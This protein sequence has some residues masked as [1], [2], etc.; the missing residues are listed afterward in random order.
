[1]ADRTLL[2]TGFQPF[3]SAPLNPSE[4]LIEALRAEEWAP[5]GARLELAVL[6]T[7]HD[8]WDRRL[9]LLI[10]KTNPAAVVQFGLS[11]KA[12]GFVLERTAVNT[13]H[14]D[15]AD[16]EGAFATS[17][18]IDPMVPGTRSSSLDL[19]TVAEAL[20]AVGLPWDWSDDAGLYICNQCFF[21]VRTALPNRPT[22]FVHI[23]YTQAMQRQVITAGT[24]MPAGTPLSDEDLLQGAKL[25]LTAVASTLP[26][27]V[28]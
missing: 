18:W 24:P 16:A 3:P 15:R 2:V 8:V 22:G 21:R 1:M 13:Q 25:I 23:P 4:W 14:T 26:T 12:H 5:D 20:D 10:E 28:G 27:M 19:N 7:V 6:P 11:A 17:S 9:R